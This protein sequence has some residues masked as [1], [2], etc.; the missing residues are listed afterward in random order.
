MRLVMLKT[1]ENQWP[2]STPGTCSRSEAGRPRPTERP[3]RVPLPGFATATQHG[4]LERQCP[5]SGRFGLI[6]AQ[7]RTHLEPV[8]Q[9]GSLPSIAQMATLILRTIDHHGN[10]GSVRRGAMMSQRSSEPSRCARRRTAPAKKRG[11]RNGG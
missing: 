9:V 6:C 5:V 7:E 3:T 1:Q 10:V 4:T 11:R 2:V 8:Q